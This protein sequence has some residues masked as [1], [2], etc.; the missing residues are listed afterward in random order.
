MV[1]HRASRPATIHQL[2]TKP[3]QEFQ[4]ALDLVTPRL[5]PKLRRLV[6]AETQPDGQNAGHRWRFFM[7]GVQQHRELMRYLARCNRR[8]SAL[9]LWGSVPQFMDWETGEI[10]ATRSELAE[11]AGISQKLVSEIMGEW[12]KVG[13]MGRFRDRHTGRY[14]YLLNPNFGTH[15]ASAPDRQADQG[16]W[17]RQLTLIDGDAA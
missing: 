13:L 2:E 7:T 6:L 3:A 12:V 5:S 17:P 10:T 4:L 11:D 15:N 16:T 8:T 14:R 1:V 9:A